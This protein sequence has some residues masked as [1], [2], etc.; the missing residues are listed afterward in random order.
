MKWVW[1]LVAFWGL[2]EKSNLLKY[3]CKVKRDLVEV[4]ERL[5]LRRLLPPFLLVG[6][7]W[8]VIREWAECED[9]VR[10]WAGKSIVP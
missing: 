1:F 10:V 9:C 5:S 2:F 4:V 6:S 3:R 7:V 8:V